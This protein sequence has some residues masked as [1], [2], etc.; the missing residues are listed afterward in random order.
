MIKDY[1]TLPIGK[2]L[3]ILAVSE[4]EPVEERRNPKILSILDGRTVEELENIQLVEFAGM[5]RQAVFLL[6]PPKAQRTRKTYECGTFRLRPVLDYKKITTAQYVDFQGFSKE[7]GE[8]GGPRVVEVLSCFLVPDGHK[9]CDGYE[10]GEVQE[11]I[12]EH[13][14]VE[15]A[16]S[17]YSFF[18]GRLLHLMRRSVTFLKQTARRLPETPETVTLKAQA[19]ALTATDLQTVGDGLLTLTPFL[20]LSAILG[21]PSGE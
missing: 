20:K 16:M 14:S 10:P 21:M 1:K 19:K 6:A 2:Y 17:L 12:R 9:Y 5:M 13:M 3:Q 18:I 7:P 4:G 8:D 15:D 11:A